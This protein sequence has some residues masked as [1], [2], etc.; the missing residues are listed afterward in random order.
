VQSPR[1]RRVF[2]KH[3]WQS[4]GCDQQ[5]PFSLCGLHHHSLVSAKV[6]SLK[7]RNGY[8]DATYNASTQFID[9]PAKTPADRLPSNAPRKVKVGFADG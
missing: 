1:R 8:G 3:V 9:Y 6:S 4:D 2:K 7:L 5:S